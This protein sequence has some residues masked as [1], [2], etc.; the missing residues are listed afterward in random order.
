[1]NKKR[2]LGVAILLFVMGC[3]GESKQVQISDSTVG[4]IESEKGPKTVE[5][6]AGTVFGGASKEQATALARIFV[7]AHNMAMQQFGKIAATQESVKETQKETQKAI[8]ESQDAMKKTAQGLE[9][10]NQKILGVAEKNLETAQKALRSLEQ[11]SQKQGTGEITLFYP[12]GE[13]KLTEKS[14][15]YKRLVDFV[16]FLARESKGRKVLF[17]SI[18]SASA[19]GK[20]SLNMKLAQ[21]RAEYPKP[22]IDKYLINIPHEYFKVYGIGDLYS[23]KVVSK[24]ERDRYQHTRLIAVFETDQIPALP[25]EP[26]KK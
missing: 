13:S 2:F 15:E 24:N 10:S 11:L 1:M 7:E 17:V 3:A 14:L 20:R 22:I 8:Q 4:A 9:E 23:P 16:D 25:E 19:V 26:A 21:N 18:G 12:I 5:F 6:P